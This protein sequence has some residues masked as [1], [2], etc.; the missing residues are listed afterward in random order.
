MRNGL[1]AIL[2][3]VLLAGL[4]GCRCPS[5]VPVSLEP[6]ND[7]LLYHGP[8]CRHYPYSCPQCPYSAYGQGDW[9]DTYPRQSDGGVSAAPADKGG[10]PS[11]AKPSERL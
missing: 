11:S 8:A 1:L 6:L 5:Q 7:W 3:V 9:G 4:G 10:A 2:A